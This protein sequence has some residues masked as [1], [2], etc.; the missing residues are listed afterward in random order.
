MGLFPQGGLIK[1]IWCHPGSISCRDSF[2]VLVDY[3]ILLDNASALV[4]LSSFFSIPLPERVVRSLV[5]KNPLLLVAVSGKFLCAQSF[6]FPYFLVDRVRHPPPFSE[7][8]AKFFID[9]RSL[10]G[11]I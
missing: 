2:T 10:L 3:S 11:G 9:V 4:Q 8:N 5:Q 1:L 7:K 6:L